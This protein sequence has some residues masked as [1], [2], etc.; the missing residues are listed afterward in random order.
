MQ[1]S[2]HRQRIFFR[3]SVHRRINHQW[4]TPV[5]QYQLGLPRCTRRNLHRTWLPPF[6]FSEHF[7]CPTPTKA[8]VLDVAIEAGEKWVEH[9]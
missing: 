5:P 2:S 9:N 1:T 8:N 6:A 7:L 3:R 4:R